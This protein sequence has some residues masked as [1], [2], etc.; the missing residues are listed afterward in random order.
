[1]GSANRF[2]DRPEVVKAALAAALTP[3]VGMMVAA[4]GG[5]A[6]RPGWLDNRGQ[7]V[8]LREVSVV[9]PLTLLLLGASAEVGPLMAF[10][11]VAASVDPTELN[12]TVAQL[13][14]GNMHINPILQTC[15]HEVQLEPE[16]SE[17]EEGKRSAGEGEKSVGTS[18]REGGVDQ[19]GLPLLAHLLD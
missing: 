8:F 14:S 2:A 10:E 17:D 19:E 1:M 12:Q 16:L 13:L 18:D 5:A 6:S 15:H 7:Q 3:H 9:S 4:A 11:R